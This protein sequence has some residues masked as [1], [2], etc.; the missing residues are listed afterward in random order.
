MA[1]EPDITIGPWMIRRGFE[2]VFCGIE[3]E[4]LE[5]E[6]EENQDRELA[7]YQSLRKSG[8]QGEDI[9]AAHAGWQ[10]ATSTR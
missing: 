7:K 2:W 9:I 3:K 8:L 6:S 10:M 4:V 1:S 5:D